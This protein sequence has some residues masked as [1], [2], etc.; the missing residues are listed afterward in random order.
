MCCWAVKSFPTR[1]IELGADKW[2]SRKKKRECR[3]Q[4]SNVATL[5][6][7]LTTGHYSSNPTRKLH[8]FLT[9]RR[10]L[11]LIRYRIDNQHYCNRGTRWRSK[12]S[13]TAEKHVI[14]VGEHADSVLK[15]VIELVH[16]EHAWVPIQVDKSVMLAE[17]K[18]QIILVAKSDG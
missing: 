16:Q 4:M 1:L 2:P 5:L 12:L 3:K 7:L 17:L 11:S 18:E 15:V 10:Y 14:A 9:H 13:C 6:L 8:F